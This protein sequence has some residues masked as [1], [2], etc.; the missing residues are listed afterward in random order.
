MRGGAKPTLALAGLARG[1]I[2]SAA[3]RRDGALVLSPMAEELRAA[4]HALR[5]GRNRTAGAAIRRATGD[6]ASAARSALRTA[7]Q[8][9]AAGNRPAA[10]AAIARALLA[11]V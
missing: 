2:L 8:A 7:R 1:W 10:E 6:M 9:L 11:L 4:L 5:A 3:R